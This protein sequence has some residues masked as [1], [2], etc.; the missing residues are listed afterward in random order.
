VAVG[1]S[2]RIVVEVKPDFKA[3][4]YAALKKR[5][6]TFKEWVTEQAEENLIPANKTRRKKET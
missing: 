6:L 5:G 3:Q 4:I 2:N 1:K